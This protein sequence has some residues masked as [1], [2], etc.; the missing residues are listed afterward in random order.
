[1]LS[2]LICRLIAL[3]FPE[4]VSILCQERCCKTVVEYLRARVCRTSRVRRFCRFS[5]RSGLDSE[6]LI[7][8]RGYEQARSVQP[9]IFNERSSFLYE[10]NY[11]VY[12]FFSYDMVLEIHTLTGELCACCQCTFRTIHHVYSMFFENRDEQVC[13]FVIGF[14]PEIFLV[15]PFRFL[16]VESC[17]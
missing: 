14:H 12:I 8:Y 17:S 13:E 16:R 3:R 9:N 5:C 6:L 2:N 15:V 10:S 7:F 11:F 1:M 4:L